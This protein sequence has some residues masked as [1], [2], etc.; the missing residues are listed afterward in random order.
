MGKMAGPI[1]EMVNLRFLEGVPMVAQL[2]EPPIM[3]SGCF[4]KTRTNLSSSPLISGREMRY[5]CN[6]F[7]LEN[8]GD[9]FC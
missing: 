5:I 7:I 8:L 1:L 4:G 3:S 6:K 2:K 9:F